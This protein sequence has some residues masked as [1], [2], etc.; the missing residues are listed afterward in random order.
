MRSIL[1]GFGPL[2]RAER[3]PSGDLSPEE[4]EQLVSKT[5]QKLLREA[6]G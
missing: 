5:L 6:K 1:D 3:P 4:L 2:P